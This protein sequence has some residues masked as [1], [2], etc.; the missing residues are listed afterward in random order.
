LQL[1]VTQMQFQ[2][3][4][5]PVDNSE[6]ISQLA[7]FSSLEQMQQLNTGFDTLS[8][9]ID[10]LNFLS[11]SSMLG[12]TVTGITASGTA[13]EGTVEKVQLNGSLVFLTVDGE[14]LSMA[15]VLSIEGVP[16]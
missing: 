12:K 16:A 9:N 13:V 6:M 11:A 4:L 5:N 7:Q 14:L 15:R 3:P 10:Q 2:D 8:G 1:L